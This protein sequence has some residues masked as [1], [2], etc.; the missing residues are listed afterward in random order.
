MSC[1]STWPVPQGARD[2]L[3]SLDAPDEDWEALRADYLALMTDALSWWFETP[4]TDAE[5]YRL[6]EPWDALSNRLVEVR[7]RETEWR[8][9]F[10]TL[11]KDQVRGR[12]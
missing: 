1:A 11:P 5:W 8:G 12:L 7:G 3:A 2:E 10:P 9:P 6:A 4:R